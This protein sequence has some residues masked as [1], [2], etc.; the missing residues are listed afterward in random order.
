M[1]VLVPG[2][3]PGIAMTNNFTPT[4]SGTNSLNLPQVNG[5]R[6]QSNNVLLDGTDDNEIFLGEA[7]AV[8]SPDAIREFSI[9]TNLYGAEFGRGA[10]SIINIVTK[11]GTD[12]FHGSAYEYLRND[13]LDARN[14]FALT[15]PPLRRNQFGGAIG[16]PVIKK[17]THFFVNY[18][19]TRLSEG[20]TMEGTVPSL[21]EKQEILAPTPSSPS[22]R[23]PDC[24]IPG[25]QFLPRRGIPLRKTC[26]NSIPT[27]TLV[28]TY[29]RRRRFRP[30]PKMK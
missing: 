30:L 28:R 29:I 16:G 6:N 17:K 26:F 20:V 2:S 5:L 27:Q 13:A 22:I 19:G 23:R 4:S 12:S 9:Q 18:E 25:I 1:T 10:G 21:L 15:R 11:S 14:F 8:P 24:P 3:V 7:A